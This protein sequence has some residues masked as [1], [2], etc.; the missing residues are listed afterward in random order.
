MITTDGYR[1]LVKEINKLK[2]Y[3]RSTVI[4]DIAKAR[5]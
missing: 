1:S 4:A 5:N 3:E 2:T